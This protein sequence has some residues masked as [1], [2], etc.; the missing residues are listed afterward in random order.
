MEVSHTSGDRD[1][2]RASDFTWSIFSTTII[3]VLVGFGG[4][5]TLVAEAARAAG[6]NPAE[7][8]SWV[9]SAAFGMGITTLILTVWHRVPAFTAWSTPGAA[10]ILS[11]A[12]GIG[13][14]NAIGA[15]IFA[16]ALVCLTAAFRPLSRLIQAIPSPIAAAMLAGVLLRFALNVPQAAAQAPLLVLPIILVWAVLR[17]VKPMFALPATM[18]VGIAIVAF[19]GSLGSK[20]CTLA[21]TP[22]VWTWPV[23]HMGTLVSLGIPLYLVT[24]AS[25]NLPGFAVLQAS[26]YRPYV[27]SSLWV[28]GLGSIAL[29]PFG[30]HALNMAAITA[31]LFTGPDCHPDPKKRWL[32]G[33]VYMVLCT[34]LALFSGSMVDLL[35]A[36]PAAVLT[37]IAGLALFNPLIGALQNAVR[38]PGEL[39]ASM[40]GFLVTASGVTALGIGSAFWGLAAG[41]AYRSFR[42]LVAARS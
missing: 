23:F 32:A 7:A 2:V 31:A 34:A 8:A 30:S 12:H 5:I 33:P 16:G 14:P 35:A 4:T 39:D 15:F 10:L 18:I 24:M 29:A 36:L 41:L 28:T 1:A 19:S 40:I 26:G 21:L 25:Q 17:V 13:L 27:S 38:E 6:A 20:C 42:Q 11:V 9:G 22:F 3:A 37:T